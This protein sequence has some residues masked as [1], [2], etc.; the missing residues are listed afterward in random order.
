M[1]EP[2][3]EREILS[4]MRSALSM[5]KQRCYSKTCR[6]YR[7]YGGRGIKVCQRWLDSFDNFVADMGLRPPGMTLERRDNNGPY[8]PSNCVWA[9][10]AEQSRNTRT[11]KKITYDGR[12]LSITEW[13]ELTGIPR[14]TLKARVSRL[15]YTAQEAL[16][17]PVKCGGLLV[18]RVYKKRRAPDMSRLPKGL[19]HPNTKLG[20][21][22]V[23]RM[24]ALHLKGETFTSL[25]KMFQVSVE[26]ASQAVQGHLAYKDV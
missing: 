24:R 8:S 15:G 12:T 5:T 13:A 19:D 11:S 7:Y 20:R 10:R 23:L 25:A 16:T 21:Q 17:K 6:D 22:Q 4:S 18:G 9:S 3:N 14:D 26:T 2:T 1:T